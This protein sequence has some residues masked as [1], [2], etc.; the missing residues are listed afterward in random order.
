MKV[1]IILLYITY[2]C[3]G[4]CAITDYFNSGKTESR[5][6]YKIVTHVLKTG[7]EPVYGFLHYEG[8]ST[9]LQYYR[10]HTNA[11]TSLAIS[12]EHHLYVNG[13]EASP[14]TVKP[15]DL[16]DTPAGPATVVR[17]E[18]TVEAGAYHPFVRGGAYYADGLLASDYNEKVPE[19]VWDVVR[20]YADARFALGVPVVPDGVALVRPNWAFT[21]L[22]ALGVSP[23]AQRPL[24]PLLVAA[25]VGTD[26]VNTA[27]AY[28]SLAL[29]AAAT[30]AAAL[31]ARKTLVGAKRA[32]AAA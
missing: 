14:A 11:S 24:F 26:L 9:S 28:P 18:T 1:V 31:A 15:G 16:L 27:A 10:L 6:K 12:A 8:S 19:L 22:D 2:I 5:Q 13:A 23:A 20:A 25:S 21:S 30:L 29:G 3:A 7:Y 4:C 17:V 32:A